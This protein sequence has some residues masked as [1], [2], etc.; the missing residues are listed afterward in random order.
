MNLCNRILNTIFFYLLWNNNYHKRISI[1]YISDKYYRYFGE[2]I[3]NIETLDNKLK[4]L[5]I[6]LITNQNLPEIFKVIAEFPYNT[7]EMYSY[8]HHSNDVEIFKKIA[9]NSLEVVGSSSGVSIVFL[10]K[11]ISSDFNFGKVYKVIKRKDN[12][13]KL[14]KQ[15][16]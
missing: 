8:E 10:N 3:S 6:D 12:L 9:K 5:N 15:L 4:A 14:I 7:D 16:H 2:D 13:N 11:Y 1:K